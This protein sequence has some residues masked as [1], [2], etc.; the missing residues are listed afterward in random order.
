MSPLQPGRIRFTE[1]GKW[2]TITV[3]RT[4]RRV[5]V[6][7]YVHLMFLGCFV[8]GALFT[9]LSALIGA[10]GSGDHGA[11]H[12]HD[13]HGFGSESGDTSSGDQDVHRGDSPLKY[14]NLYSINGFL[15]WFGAVGL[16]L[17]YL[18]GWPISITLAL[19]SLAGLGGAV[20][21]AVFLARLR[22]GEKVM[23]AADYRME[24]T[25]GRVSVSIPTAGVGEIVFEKQGTRRSEAARSEQ[26]MAI[27]HGTEVMVVK[28]AGGVASVRPFDDVMAERFPGS[29]SR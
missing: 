18:V 13:G 11:P 20:T 2:S 24:G 14:V 6:D 21:M 1:L 25:L 5:H 10:I 22:S 15:T 3:L 19:A 16:G 27:P 28:Y 26:G 12:D 4:A 17:S 8:F 29:A 7:S 23:R 9:L